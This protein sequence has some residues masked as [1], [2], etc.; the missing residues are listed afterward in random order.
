[1][2]HLVVFARWPEPGRVKTRL[3]PPLTAEQACELHRAMLADT[4]EVGRAASVDRRYLYWADAPPDRPWSAEA[5]EAGYVESLQRGRDLGAR[6]EAVFDDL[7]APPGARVAVIGTDCP[8]L[9]PALL[10]DAFRCLEAHDLV[11]GPT[12][13]GGYYLVGLRRAAP[14]IFRAI[15]WGSPTVLATTIERAN[16]RAL[17]VTQLPILGDL[18]TPADLE[19]LVGLSAAREPALPRGTAA[20]LARLRA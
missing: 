4:L 3:S 15:P 18:D 12:H 6:L 20:A 7:L 10:N 5:R 17:S 1:M 8:E 19:R 9:P 16:G 13:D 14:E 11:L 2:N